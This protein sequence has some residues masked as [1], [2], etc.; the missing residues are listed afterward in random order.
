M[1]LPRPLSLARS[2]GL[3]DCTIWME[4]ENPMHTLCK[5][6][7]CAGCF[8]DRYFLEGRMDASDGKR[9]LQLTQIRA[10]STNNLGDV[11]LSPFLRGSGIKSSVGI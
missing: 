3:S 9:A 4:A 2:R 1:L 5:H 10:D 11:G 6:V 8:E 7:Y